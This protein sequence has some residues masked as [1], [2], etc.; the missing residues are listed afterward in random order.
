MVKKLKTAATAFSRLKQRAAPV[1]SDIG[2]GRTC[3][4]MKF[5]VLFV[6][7]FFGCKI[8]HNKLKNYTHQSTYYENFNFALYIPYSIVLL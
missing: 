3:K 1:A 8:L 5:A 7:R 6:N 4:I 2:Y